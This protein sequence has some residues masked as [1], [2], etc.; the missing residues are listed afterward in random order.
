M[1]WKLA[2]LPDSQVVTGNMK[3]SRR[4][5]TSAAPQGSVLGP[6]LFNLFN[7]VLDN[8]TECILSKFADDTQLRGVADTLESC[9]AI[10]KVL[11]RLDK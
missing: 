9:A 2:E 8:G 7:D 1:D 11:E 5:L 3:S 6:V 10:Q 4:P